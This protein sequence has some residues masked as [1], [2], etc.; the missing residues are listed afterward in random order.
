MKDTYHLLF[1][2]MRGEFF[3]PLLKYMSKNITFGDVTCRAK[4]YAKLSEVDR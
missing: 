3:H 2:K 1:F 4:K